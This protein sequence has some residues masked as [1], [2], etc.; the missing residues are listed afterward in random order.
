MKLE[1][2]WP[3][4]ITLN[5]YLFIFSPEGT[6]RWVEN[7]LDGVSHRILISGTGSCWKPVT[8]GVP[9]GSKLGAVLFNFPIN[10]L[11]EGA[12]ATLSQ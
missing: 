3:I 4:I 12:D 7:W 11:D 6:T 9:Q 2:H 1:E 8:S 5:V 10:D